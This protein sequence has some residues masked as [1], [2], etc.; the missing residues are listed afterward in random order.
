MRG[1]RRC[2]G[3]ALL[4]A[5]EPPN[6]LVAV[7]R[8]MRSVTDAGRSA[9]VQ[10]MLD[11]LRE[12]QQQLPLKGKRVRQRCDDMVGFHEKALRVLGDSLQKLRFNSNRESAA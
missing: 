12:A 7:A 11:R 3:K 2:F 8:G 4:G 5:E 1:T 9:R 6:L 10:R